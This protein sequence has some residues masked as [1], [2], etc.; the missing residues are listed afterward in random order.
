[1]TSDLLEIIFI[2][3]LVEMWCADMKNSRGKDGMYF[4]QSIFIIYTRGGGEK[5]GKIV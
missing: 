1:M 3:R 2:T 5:E 4:P